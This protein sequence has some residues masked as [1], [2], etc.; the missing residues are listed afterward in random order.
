MAANIPDTIRYWRDEDGTLRAS[1]KQRHVHHSDGFEVG[2]GGSGPADFALNILALLLPIGRGERVR[3]F[4]GSHVSQRAWD[5]HQKLKWQIISRLDPAGGEISSGTI[6]EWIQAREA[7]DLVD[8]AL[9]R[10]EDQRVDA[11]A[12]LE[13]GAG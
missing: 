13:S 11:V 12:A 9:Q 1:I 5:L 6:R 4:N 7:E 3:C 8:A 10:V 2:Y